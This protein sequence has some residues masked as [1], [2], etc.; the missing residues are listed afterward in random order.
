M[1]SI[2]KFKVKGWYDLVVNEP[3]PLTLGEFKAKYI[4]AGDEVKFIG[5]PF[6]STNVLVDGKIKYILVEVSV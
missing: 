6:R 4:A 1:I 2:Q 5:A 3:L